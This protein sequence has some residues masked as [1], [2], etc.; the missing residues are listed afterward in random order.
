MALCEGKVKYRIHN[1]FAVILNKLLNKQVNLQVIWT[2]MTLI[3][4]RAHNTR[5]QQE[6][7]Y[8]MTT[9]RNNANGRSS[10]LADWGSTWQLEADQEWHGNT[11]RKQS[12][13]L[14][15][16]SSLLVIKHKTL[17]S[18]SLLS[19]WFQ[20]HPQEMIWSQPLCDLCFTTFKSKTTGKNDIKTFQWNWCIINWSIK[21]CRL[22]YLHLCSNAQCRARLRTVIFY[23]HN[24]L[25]LFI[26]LMCC[27]KFPG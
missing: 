9:V 20:A 21:R 23:T 27:V 19:S 10:Q 24:R 8:M 17:C 6:Y 18:L 16:A 2:V 26:W 25:S 11:P 15:L 4:D 13:Q 3:L 12:S 1:F 5:N 7:V 14:Q 22:T